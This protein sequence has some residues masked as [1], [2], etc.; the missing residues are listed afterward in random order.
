VFNGLLEPFY[1][2]VEPAL[3]KAMTVLV[4]FQKRCRVNLGAAP[5]TNHSFESLAVAEVLRRL[6]ANRCLHLGLLL[7]LRGL[8]SKAHAIRAITAT[9]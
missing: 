2:C 7:V 3:Q 8:N 4:G 1:F 5:F 9:S 6:D